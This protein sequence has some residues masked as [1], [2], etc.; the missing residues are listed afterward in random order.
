FARYLCQQITNDLPDKFGSSDE[1][2]DDE[3]EGDDQ[4]RLILW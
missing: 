2:D 4:Y 3:E 1:S